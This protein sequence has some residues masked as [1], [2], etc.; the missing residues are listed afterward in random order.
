MHKQRRL[1]ALGAPAALGVLLF[2]VFLLAAGG[3]WLFGLVADPETGP[4]GPDRTG[5]AAVLEPAPPPS[6]GAAPFVARPGPGGG[7][8]ARARRHRPAR[9]GRG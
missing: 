3:R 8:S 7:R 1:S 9:P 4:G 6:S 5:P 2:T